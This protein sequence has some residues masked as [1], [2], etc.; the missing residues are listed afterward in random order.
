MR[1]FVWDGLLATWVWRQQCSWQFLADEERRV[2][3]AQ[4]LWRQLKRE[5]AAVISD[6]SYRYI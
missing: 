1:S 3:D 5:S 2:V 6:R 4:I